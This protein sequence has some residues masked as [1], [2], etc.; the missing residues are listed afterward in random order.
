MPWSRLDRR[1]LPRLRTTISGERTAATSA[2]VLRRGRRA[3][4]HDA[5]S[6]S[7]MNGAM[8][9]ASTTSS[10]NVASRSSSARWVPAASKFR[11]A[12]GSP[13]HNRPDSD[14]RRLAATRWRGCSASWARRATSDAGRPGRSR[15]FIAATSLYSV[16]RRLGFFHRISEEWCT[17]FSGRDTRLGS[18]YRL[19]LG[20]RSQ[21]GRRARSPFGMD[22]LRHAPPSRDRSCSTAWTKVCEV[23]SRS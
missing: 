11:R 10:E 13:A 22:S 2:K 17:F 7:L 18:P 21:L 1:V 20:T 6:S 19:D 4:A 16:P 5:P 8:Q 14:I 15:R 23:R 12:A 3:E 9:S